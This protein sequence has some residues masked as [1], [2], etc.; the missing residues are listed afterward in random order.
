MSKSN[1]R[2]ERV[3]KTIVNTTNTK[4]GKKKT[5]E[6]TRLSPYLRPVTK[7]CTAISIDMKLA[8]QVRELAGL[9]NESF[10]SIIQKCVEEYLPVL[11]SQHAE[12]GTFNVQSMLN[13]VAAAVMT[14]DVRQCGVMPSTVLFN[15]RGQIVLTLQR[16]VDESGNIVPVKLEEISKP[17]YEPFCADRDEMTVR[18]MKK[19]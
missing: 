10:S 19:V 6:R 2:L 5:T 9:Q 12:N 17:N 4:S 14:P 18:V 16:I 11:K 1:G 3:M 8:D 13:R 7:Q 15:E